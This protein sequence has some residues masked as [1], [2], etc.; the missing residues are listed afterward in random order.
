M[1]PARPPRLV[2]SA[3]VTGAATLASRVLGLVRDQVLAAV[4]G[5]IRQNPA[6]QGLVDADRAA[7]IDASFAVM[8]ANQL[9]KARRGYDALD[10]LGFWLPVV[11]VAL[12]LLT[13]LL[14]VATTTLAGL[15][16]T[17]R[18]SRVQPA[19]QLKSN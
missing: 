8:D 10:T 1:T 19:W 13:L 2:R 5:A 15:Y 16:P 9:A 18:V 6:A 7:D 12:V 11:W 17:F 14:A 4:F 3:G